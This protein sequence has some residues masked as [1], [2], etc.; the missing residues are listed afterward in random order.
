MEI[1][2]IALLLLVTVA[3]LTDVRQGRI[4]N[5]LTY[6]AILFGV[7]LAAAEGTWP[8]LRSSLFGLA[9]GFG[10]FFVLYMIGGLGGGDVK[11]MAAVGALMG[12]PFT[13]NALVTSILAGGLIA[14]LLVIWEGKARQAAVYLGATLG[15]LVMPSL[16]RAPLEARQ[17]VPFGV[18]IC[19][20]SFLTL[21]S[22]W[23]GFESPARFLGSL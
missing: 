11:L 12:Y 8:G 6:P 3:A 9:L 22:I 7:C 19:L 20:G 18:A 23:Q 10:P 5:G 14:L 13:L 17:N 15:R 21:I 4:P 16:P 1:R 2:E